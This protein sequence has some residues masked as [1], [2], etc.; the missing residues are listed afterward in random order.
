MQQFLIAFEVLL[1]ADCRCTIMDRDSLW[2]T[3]K[4][5]RYDG[6]AHLNQAASR[7]SRKVRSCSNSFS[8]SYTYKMQDP[9]A[10]MTNIL[11]VYWCIDSKGGQEK[12]VHA[13]GV[14]V[15][16]IVWCDVIDLEMGKKVLPAMTKLWNTLAGLY[17]LACIVL[18][19]RDYRSCKIW[20]LWQSAINFYMVFVNNIPIEPCVLRTNFKVCTGCNESND[21]TDFA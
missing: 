15:C 20:H 11:C 21:D 3:R 12:E 2:S 13:K 14:G 17:S 5:R 8:W 19:G 4:D 1:W 16:L 6:G 18:C 10:F 7:R 9:T